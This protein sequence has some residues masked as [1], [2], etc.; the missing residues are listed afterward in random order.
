MQHSM[1]GA[2]VNGSQWISQQT[3]IWMS[4]V[5]IYLLSTRWRRSGTLLITVWWQIYTSSWRIGSV[6]ILINVTDFSYS[7]AGSR[8]EQR[9]PV[10]T[11]DLTM[12]ELEDDWADAA[13]RINTPPLCVPS[14][15]D[16]YTLIY[17][18]LVISY[19][20]IYH[21]FVISYPLIYHTLVTISN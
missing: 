17:S 9:V 7:N 11:L 13:T 18:I 20:L 21:V 16:S 3:C 1:S 8:I 6:Q 15:H 2:W 10:P 14:Y 19:P 4:M 12:L 5:A